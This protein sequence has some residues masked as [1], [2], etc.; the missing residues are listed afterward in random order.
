MRLISVDYNHVFVCVHRIVHLSFV[1]KKNLQ[2]QRIM[3]SISSILGEVKSNIS[4]N[5]LPPF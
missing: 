2:Y 5:N 3:Q 1:H 4:I